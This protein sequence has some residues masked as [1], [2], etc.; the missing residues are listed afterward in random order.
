M[1]LRALDVLVADDDSLARSIVT[2]ILRASGIGKIRQVSN[3]EDA[4]AEVCLY[5]PD[6]VVLD[7]QMPQDGALTLRRIRQSPENS[8]RDIAVIAM[9]AYSD[10]RRIEMLRDAGASEIVAKPLS[11]ASLHARLIA[12]IDRPRPFVTASA[13][14]GP[15]RRRRAHPDA[16]RRRREDLCG[17]TLEVA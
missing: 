14:V 9:T 16:P 6:I 7:L 15:D 3:G 8:C 2:D 10:R 12:V 13:Y 11:V 4:F 5:R 17:D 1:S